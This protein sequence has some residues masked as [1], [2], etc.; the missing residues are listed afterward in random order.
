[1]MPIIQTDVTIRAV[2][3]DNIYSRK[4]FTLVL[5]VFPQPGAAARNEL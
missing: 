1:M 3:Q 4:C 2:R 5:T